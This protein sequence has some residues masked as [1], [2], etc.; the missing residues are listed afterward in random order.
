MLSK[1]FPEV[2]G[3]KKHESPSDYTVSHPKKHLN[4]GAWSQSV[5]SWARGQTP[6]K[7]HGRR[8]GEKSKRRQ[9]SDCI[10]VILA[11]KNQD[12]RDQCCDDKTGNSNYPVLPFGRCLEKPKI[13]ML[14]RQCPNFISPYREDNSDRKKEKKGGDAN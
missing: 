7:S 9:K 1:F 10:H 12:E 4:S 8:T 6:I 2:L 14:N 13:F 3:A 11:S 5:W